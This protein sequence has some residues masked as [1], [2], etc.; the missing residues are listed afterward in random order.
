MSS[1]CSLNDL[2]LVVVFRMFVFTQSV[3]AFARKTAGQHAL[4]ALPEL[5]I[6][7]M[8][9]ACPLVVLTSILLIWQGWSALVRQSHCAWCW[10]SFHLMRW[11]P[12]RWSST[13]CL[14]HDRQLRVHSA[15]RRARRLAGERLP[16]EVRA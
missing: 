10:K 13:I 2:S 9:L 1:L 6:T 3:G 14:H 7:R 12:R 15:A 4:L 11:Y 16:G 5:P 8:I